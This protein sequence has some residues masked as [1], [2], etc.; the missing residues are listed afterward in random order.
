MK[1]TMYELEN[2]RQTQERGEN[3]LYDSDCPDMLPEQDPELPPKEDAFYDK[4]FV[5]GKSE[6][7]RRELESLPE[8]FDTCHVTDEQMEQIVFETEMETRDRLR[9][10]DNESID[11]D[12]DRH[13]E[14][15]WEEMEKTVVRHGI[16]Y[17]EDE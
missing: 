14:V 12:D 16:P 3:H 2:I 4:V 8:P 17:Y 10:G 1:L 13:S 11:F 15:W 5:C 7:S 6:L 9:L